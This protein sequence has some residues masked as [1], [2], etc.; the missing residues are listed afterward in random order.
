L[1]DQHRLIGLLLR[2]ASPLSRAA[3]YV[4]AALTAAGI[5]YHVARASPAFL[6]HLEDDYFYYATIADNLVTSGKLSYD[7]ITLTNGFHPLWFATIVLLRTLFGRFGSAFYAALVLVSLAATLLTYELGRRFARSLGAP[8]SLSAPISAI[9][10]LGTARLFTSGMEA[11]L[12]V[13]LFLW[14]LVEIASGGPVSPRRATRLGAIASLAVLARLDI[15]IAVSL[16]VGAFV[17][18]VRPSLSTLFRLAVAFASGAVL[19]PVYAV[20]NMLFFGSPFPMSMLAKGFPTALGFNVKYAQIVALGTLYGPTVALV[21]PLGFLA[22][23]WLVWREPA[24]RPSA[25]FAGGLA[26]GFA[27]LFFA[28]NALTGWAFFG[29]Y[30]YPLA[31]ATLAALVFLAELWG[32]A[33]PPRAR[34]VAVAVLVALAPAFA[35]RDFVRHGPLWS[36]ADNALLAMAY[37]LADHMRDR[38]GL[39]AMGAVAG[40]ASYVM[41]R[42]VLQLEGIVSDRRLVDHIKHEDPLD[43]VLREYGADYLVVTLASVRSQPVGGCYSITQP[44][45]E[46]AGPR[47]RKMR[48]QICTEPM[49]RFLTPKG[50]HSWS[51]FTELETLVWDLRNAR[52][53]RRRRLRHARS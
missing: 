20:A 45:A 5:L 34:V 33:V 35:L 17:I 11:V 39:I 18:C 37:D 31:A 23:V 1:L 12:A 44:H 41:D 48:G 36:V 46:W 27:F 38:D 26:L 50:P 14:L 13:P 47:S 51:R 10:S 9:Y 24:I 15:A 52:W 21:L 22:C 2:W 7:G 16:A 25:R 19:V 53:K 8:A 43:E 6:G 3:A 29:W 49:E 32:P 30:A 42:P 40:V 28:L 4:V